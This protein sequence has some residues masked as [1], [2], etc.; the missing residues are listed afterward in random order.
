M[1]W[2]TMDWGETCRISTSYLID[3]QYVMKNIIFSA[4]LFLPL[5]LGAQTRIFIKAGVGSRVEIAPF[6]SYQT[7][8]NQTAQ[9]H[10]PYFLG[11]GFTKHFK[12]WDFEFSQAALVQSLTIKNP[13]NN[14]YGLEEWIYPILNDEVVQIQNYSL[15]LEVGVKIPLQKIENHPLLF[16]F[17][18]GSNVWMATKIAGFTSQNGQLFKES[19]TRKRDSFPKKQSEDQIVPMDYF[20]TVGLSMGLTKRCLVGFQVGPRFAQNASGAPFSGYSFGKKAVFQQMLGS[21]STEFV[22]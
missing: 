18:L 20:G 14:L 3:N 5:F 22:F 13:N 17:T 4:L 6:F 1:V 16:R 21:V 2:I 12:K 15:H 9:T 8:P 7:Y 19:E 11:C 10:L